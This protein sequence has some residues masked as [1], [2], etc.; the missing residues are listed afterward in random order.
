MEKSFSLLD[1]CMIFLR[2]KK[3]ILT[4][5]ITITAV[6][7]GI[8]YIIPKTYKAVALFLPPYSDDVGFAGLSLGNLINIGRGSA[9]TP[10]QIESLLY[11]R[12]VLE[13]AV[14]EF[15]L[16]RVYKLQKLPNRNEQAIK[17]LTQKIDLQTATESGLTQKTIVHYSLSVI[18]KDR[19]RSAEIT[20]FLVDEL[21]R[22]MDSL[23]RAP[24]DYAEAFVKGRLD[25]VVILKELTQQRLA[26]FQKANKIYAPAMAPQVVASVNT[27]AE[28]SQQ[29]IMSE[30]QRELLLYDRQGKSREVAYV[31]RKIQE[32]ERKMRDIEDGRAPNVMP[33]LNRS[34]DVSYE[35][36][37]MIQEAEI[38]TKLELLLRQQYEEARIKRARAA[39]L[40]RVVD[41]AR[42]PEWKN[43]PKKAI[44]VLVIVIVY[45]TALL[46]HI[47][48]A[49]GVSQ[50]S[51][52]TREKLRRFRESLRLRA[53]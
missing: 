9:F 50:A 24:Y 39:P 11:S 3:R 43:F 53:G 13:A 40:V 6:A 16:I 14:R 20:N 31:D 38:L 27:Y 10:Q 28:L 7:V 32:L 8:S 26:T 37:D 34:V 25:S 29:K 5:F 44:V 21:G 2:R 46:L 30:I 23:S 1:F 49:H 19:M 4:H 47:L 52:E 36:L 18:D 15:D 35:Y 22:I 42:P 48:L 17:K 33:G 41:R 12:R 51:P 45:M